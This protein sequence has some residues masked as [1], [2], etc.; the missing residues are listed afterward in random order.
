MRLADLFSQHL[1]QRRL[2]STGKRGLARPQEDVAEVKEVHMYAG[3]TMFT[4]PPGVR[5][6]MENL[7][8]QMLVGMK[9]MK[10]FV[11]IT[12]LLDEET[13]EYGGIA[14]WETKED[15]E[16]AMAQTGAKLEE[17]LAGSVIG[18][19]RRNLYEVYESQA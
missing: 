8:D 18:P 19:L 11:S 17:V 14:L 12:F 16:A 5:E 1:A 4:M 3:M 10:G 15:A 13:N 7:A 6:K 9:Q 2:S